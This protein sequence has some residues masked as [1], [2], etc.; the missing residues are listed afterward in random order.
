MQAELLFADPSRGAPFDAAAGLDDYDSSGSE[1]PSWLDADLDE[2][3]AAADNADRAASTCGHV[4]AMC[5]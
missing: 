3:N 5:L 4:A 2:G 1:Q